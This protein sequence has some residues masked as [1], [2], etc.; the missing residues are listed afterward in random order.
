[1]GFLSD[2][3]KTKKKMD[4]LLG[5]KPTKKAEP[6]VKPKP[7]PK[8]VTKSK[9]FTVKC[10]NELDPTLSYDLEGT[11]LLNED[12]DVVGTLP[13]SVEEFTDLSDTNPDIEVVDSKKVKITIEY[14]K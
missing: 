12:G 13:D 9:T 4:K 3:K 2:Y 10:T 6:K 7:Q 8:I 5:I 1:M 11:E 14:E